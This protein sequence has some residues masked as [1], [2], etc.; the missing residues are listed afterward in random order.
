LEKIPKSKINEFNLKSGDGVFIVEKDFFSTLNEKEKEYLKPLIE[1]T[2]VE[3]YFFPK[4]HTQELIYFTKKNFNGENCPTLISHLEKFKEI[5]SERRE[6]KN[7]QMEF[8]HIHWPRDQRFFTKGEKILS[9]RKC[10]KPTF[11]YTENEAYVTGK[12]NVLKTNRV[13]L[14]YLTA[15][16]N[17]KMIAF[18]LKYK[19]KMQGDNFQID[20]EP[21]LALPLLQPSAEKQSELAEL[22]TK[23]IDNKQKQLDYTDLLKKTK[24][25]NNFEREILLTKE[26]DSFKTLIDKAERKIDSLVYELYELS[27]K[28]IL[29]IEN[30][31]K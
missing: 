26:L 27:D 30:E 17:S 29:T 3:R 31:I 19:G 24:A 21:L 20:K 11:V 10:K 6:T 12:F 15:L 23:I 1:A 2:E 5:M 13:N 18:W 22:A 8:Y 7:G 25:E 16:L 9:V 14:K 28:D 4:K